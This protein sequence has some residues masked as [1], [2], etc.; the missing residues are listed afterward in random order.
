MADALRVAETYFD[1]WNRRDAAA[2][3][4]SFADGGT[5]TDPLAPGL[6]GDALAAYVAGLWQAFPD[7][8]F[9]LDG[10]A[11]VGGDTVAAQWVMTGTNTGPFHGLP[12]TG[13]S[14]RLP[15]ADFIRVEDGRIRSVHGYF[16]AGAVPRQLGLQVVVQPE[17][18][19][20]FRFG[21]S[22]GVQGG[23]RSRPG[24]FGITMLHVRNAEEVERMRT[25]SRQ[26]ALEMLEMPGFIGWTAMALGDR[27]YNVSA[28][29]D[30]E[31]I[32]RLMIGGTHARAM[33]DFFGPGIGAGG[34]TSVWVPERINAM[35]VRC[36]GCDRMRPHLGPD[37][38]CDCGAALPEPPEYW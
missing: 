1:A 7:L 26:I 5:Y 28:W 31:S 30:V 33:A 15:G 25:Y 38:R 27:L 12:P 3:V 16:D 34:F 2:I 23:R 35:W 29:E 20:P 24:A 4:A 36:R 13:R 9:E 37:S 14:I 19:G 18:L 32:G 8:A 21:S 22:V 6:S 17:A 10:A 11:L